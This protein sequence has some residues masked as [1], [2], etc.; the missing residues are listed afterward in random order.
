MLVAGELW[1]ARADEPIEKDERVKVISS[2]GMEIKVKKH[3]E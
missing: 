2:D 1:R 3:A